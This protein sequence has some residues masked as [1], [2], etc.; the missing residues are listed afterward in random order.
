VFQGKLFVAG[1]T[2]DIDDYDVVEA[3]NPTS[4][5]WAAKAHMPTKRFSFAA[6]A[7]G[8]FLYAVGGRIDASET[9]IATNELYRP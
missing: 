8:G 5:T 4:N 7:A 6:S 3:Y 2:N 9:S 1:G